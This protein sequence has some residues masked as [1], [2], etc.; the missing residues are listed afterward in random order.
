MESQGEALATILASGRFPML[1]SIAAQPGPDF[2]L[3]LDTLF[4][5]GLQL[6]LDGLAVLIHPET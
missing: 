4:G 6:L 3:D 2:R 1:S 5:F